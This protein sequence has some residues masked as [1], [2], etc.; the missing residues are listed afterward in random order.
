MVPDCSPENIRRSVDAVI[1]ALDGKKKVDLF[2]CARVDSRV[3]HRSFCYSVPSLTLYTKGIYRRNHD[4]V[5]DV[6]GGRQV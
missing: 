2:E 5:E 6:S 1:K 3:C 4:N